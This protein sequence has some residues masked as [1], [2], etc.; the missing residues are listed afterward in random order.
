MSDIGVNR[1]S[2]RL[3][4]DIQRTGSI[5]ERIQI[6]VTLKMSVNSLKSVFCILF[7]SRDA[8]MR[9]ISLIRVVVF[10]FDLI[11]STRKWQRILC[12]QKVEIPEKG[13]ELNRG[14]RLTSL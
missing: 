2:A 13:E 8:N 1:P 11:I 10:F 12:Q 9:V 14:G 4:G 5:P 3:S 6:G 7:A